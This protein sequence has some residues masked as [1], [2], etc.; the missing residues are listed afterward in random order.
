MKT[1]FAIAIA[2][3]LSACSTH[4]PAKMPSGAPFPINPKKIEK[5]TSPLVLTNKGN[6]NE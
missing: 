6:I 1:L 2:L 4:K 3:L 5:P